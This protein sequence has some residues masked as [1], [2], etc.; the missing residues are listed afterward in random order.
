MVADGILTLVDTPAGKRPFRTVVDGLGMGDPIQ[1][2]NEVA[3][4]TTRGIYSA[5]GMEKMLG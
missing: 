4:E 1:K 3:Q 5:F 2:Y